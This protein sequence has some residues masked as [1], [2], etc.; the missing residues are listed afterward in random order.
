[1]T[2]REDLLIDAQGLHALLQS[3]RSLPADAP[4][5]RL[6][7][8]RWTLTVNT[9]AGDDTPPVG[10][11]DYRAGHIPTAVFV[12]LDR[13]LAEHGAPGEGRHPLPSTERLQAAVTRWGINDGDAVIVYDGNG[14][15][16][17]ARAWW[18]LRDAGVPS[19][20]LLDGALPAWQLSGYDLETGVVTPKPGNFVIAPGQ[21]PRLEL[22]QIEPFVRVGGVLLDARAAE[23][24]R[25]EHEPID[26]Q[27]GHIPG[28][29]N[30]PTAQNLDA[31]G[32]FLPAEVLRASFG[33]VDADPSRSVASYCGSGVTAAHNLV[34]L[35]LAG[36]E[37][38]LYPGSWSQWSNHSELPVA[39][40]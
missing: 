28:A 26:P 29:R 11:D 4:R 16:A 23:R 24:Y 15:L 40:G 8:V 17:S 36:I 19:V 6:L 34:A 39:T 12:D 14:N 18:L 30:T 10:F 13:E 3:E 9:A 7:D 33:A 32:R 37:G 21:S 38:A 27:A 35:A 2:T 5:T 20:R 1:M 25:G 22:A 31:Q